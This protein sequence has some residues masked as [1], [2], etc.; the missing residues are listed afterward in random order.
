MNFNPDFLD[1]NIINLTSKF[2]NWDCCIPTI[3]PF[4][5]LEGPKI[6]CKRPKGPY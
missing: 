1:F 5:N 2:S 4:S 3:Y 6:A